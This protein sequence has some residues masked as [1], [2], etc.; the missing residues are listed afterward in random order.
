MQI[1]T[2]CPGCGKPLTLDMKH[3]EPYAPIGEPTVVAQ[4]RCD[5]CRQ[6]VTISITITSEATTT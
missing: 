3:R 4:E 1:Y 6:Q 5:E 2:N